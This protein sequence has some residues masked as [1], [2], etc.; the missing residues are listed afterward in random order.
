MT[1]KI[2]AAR[3][4]GDITAE[5]LTDPKIVMNRK[6]RRASVKRFQ[7]SG[8][9]QPSNDAHRID[10]L[11]TDAVS[12]QNSGRLDT[13]AQLYKQLL[14]INPNQPLVCNKLACVYTAQGKLKDASKWFA[15][16]L[17]LMPQLLDQYGNILT[18]LGT[19]VP[20]IGVAVTRAERA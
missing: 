18:T 11:F 15:R 19:V 6:Q 8:D 16:S 7:P 14:S 1:L 10:R 5:A 9:V 20:C 13:A 17:T 12:H 4:I 3:T 2:D